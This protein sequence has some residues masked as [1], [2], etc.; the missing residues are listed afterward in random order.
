MRSMV[1]PSPAFLRWNYGTGALP[2]LYGRRWVS[3]YRRA[4]EAG[5][6]P[7]A[8][9]PTEIQPPARGSDTGVARSGSDRSPDV[10]PLVTPPRPNGSAGAGR[11]RQER[12]S[13]TRP[14]RPV[15]AHRTGAFRG[16]GGPPAEPPVEPAGSD[17]VPDEPDQPRRGLA[18][19]V[20]PNGVRFFIGGFALLVVTAMV[21][22]RGIAYLGVV[23]DPRRGAAVRRRRVA[24][25][26]PRPTR[27]STGWGGG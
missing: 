27:T 5:S 11:S 21:A 14:P 22:Q 26:H 13:E 25:D 4:T 10:P 12:W 1:A 9:A 18:T 17:G 7:P 3:L 8:G 19:A 16:D 6:N 24:A 20:A 23:S 15:P 2:K